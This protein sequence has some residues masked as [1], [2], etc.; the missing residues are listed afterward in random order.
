M[1]IR[2]IVASAIIALTLGFIVAH[3]PVIFTIG[4]VLWIALSVALAPL[5]GRWLRRC[6]GEVTSIHN[7]ADTPKVA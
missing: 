3:A 6:A 7:G 2:Q 4:I 1:L 5:F